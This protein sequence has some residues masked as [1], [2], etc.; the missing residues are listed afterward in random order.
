MML[1]SYYRLSSWLHWG[2]RWNPRTF[3]FHNGASTSQLR[4]TE[5]CKRHGNDTTGCN[6]ISIAF[7]LS[8]HFNESVLSQVCIALKA[9]Y[10]YCLTFTH[11]Y[12][13]RRRRQT[14]RLVRALRVRGLAQVQLDGGIELAT[15]RLQVNLL[16]LLSH[17]CAFI[18]NIGFNI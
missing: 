11:S 16:C 7:P 18:E 13:H 17:C 12:T 9:F 4:S 10:N 15:V 6:L 3:V 2:A 5:K 8:T 14:R 1:G